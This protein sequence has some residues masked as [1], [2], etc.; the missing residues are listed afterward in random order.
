MAQS[1]W[2]PIETPPKDGTWV[3]VLCPN[4]EYVALWDTY[5]DGMGEWASWHG[6]GEPTHWMPLPGPPESEGESDV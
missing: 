6:R 2:R 5:Q 3:R 4:G 1:E